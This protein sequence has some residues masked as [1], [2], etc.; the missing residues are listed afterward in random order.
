MH[1][2]QAENLGHRSR[3]SSTIASSINKETRPSYWRDLPRIEVFMMMGKGASPHDKLPKVRMHSSL[4]CL[5]A[6]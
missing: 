6:Q 4:R 1:L 3:E 2:L 5:P